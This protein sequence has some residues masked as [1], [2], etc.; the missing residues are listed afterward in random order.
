MKL[1]VGPVPQGGC[2]LQPAAMQRA[3]LL[4]RGLRLLAGI[5]QQVQRRSGHSPDPCSSSIV[6]L[7]G[8]GVLGEHCCV[9]ISLA[10]PG[11]YQ[12]K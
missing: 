9:L 3:L 7:H 6:L 2:R 11:M 12:C 10:L 1:E 8:W 4:P 5:G